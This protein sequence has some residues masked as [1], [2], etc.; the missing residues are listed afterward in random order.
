MTQIYIAN[1]LDKH[2]DVMVNTLAMS[3]AK[4]LK[5][6]KVGRQV[7]YGDF[8]DDDLAMILRN[9]SKYGMII[10]SDVGAHLGEFIPY[11][12]S[13]GAPMSDDEVI[14][15]LENNW[16]PSNGG[17]MGIIYHIKQ[18]GSYDASTMTRKPLLEHTQ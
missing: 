17:M 12:Y 3:K 14:T 9:H 16:P 7:L 18:Y 10:N 1:G 13:L 2:L 6:V 11:I 8:N 15:L 5:T 4:Y